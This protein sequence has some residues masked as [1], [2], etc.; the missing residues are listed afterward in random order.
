MNYE[1][2]TNSASQT[3]PGARFTIRRMS[4][5]RRV[6]L[7]RHLRELFQ[8]IEFLEAG[9]DPRESIEAALLTAEIDRT[10][11]LWGLARTE[12]LEIDGQAATPETLAAAGPE[13]L[14][15]EIVA[16]IRLECGLTEAERKN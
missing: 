12:G 2:C 11:L 3:H 13:D 8:R 7:T 16:A 9:K 1:S 14:C 4:F 5:E 15:R 6:E 10:Y